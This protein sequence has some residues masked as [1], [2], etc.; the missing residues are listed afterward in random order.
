[1]LTRDTILSILKNNK[2]SL[3]ELGVQQIGIFGSYAKNEAKEKSDIDVFTKLN[4]TDYR[5]IL[6]VLLFLESKLPAKI[7][8]IYNGPHLR[9]SFLQTLEREVIYA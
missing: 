7:D 8:L 3:E 4:K 1:M 9:T 2:S 5:T 6:N